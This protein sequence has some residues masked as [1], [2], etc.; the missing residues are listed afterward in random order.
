[1]AVLGSSAVQAVVS[2]WFYRG[3]KAIINALL[4]LVFSVIF[5]V[6]FVMRI[7]IVNADIGIMYACISVVVLQVFDESHISE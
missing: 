5:V 1:M 4:M 3:N 6:V 7:D 2:E